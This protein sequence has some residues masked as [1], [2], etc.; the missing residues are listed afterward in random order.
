MIFVDWVS[1]LPATALAINSF[2][3]FFQSKRKITR[4]VMM[5][6]REYKYYYD[7]VNAFP[8]FF[9]KND[10]KNCRQELLQTL[11]GQASFRRIQVIR[12]Y[13]ESV[14]NRKTNKIEQKVVTRSWQEIGKINPWIFIY[15][16]FSGFW[17]I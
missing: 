1:E 15:L 17:A 6:I 13:I 8:V 11:K 12:I 14:F 3:H 9:I 16:F 4:P 2:L 5:L 10:E 7:S